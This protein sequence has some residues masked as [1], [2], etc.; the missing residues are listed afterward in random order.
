MS[1]TLAQENA[2]PRARLAKDAL[3]T[4]ASLAIL[5]IAGLSIFAPPRMSFA[6]D[7]TTQAISSD[8]AVVYG[9]VVDGSDRPVR[10]ATVVIV[11]EEN[12]DSVQVAA[13]ATA[14]DGTFRTELTGPFGQ[15]RVLVSAD[16]GGNVVRDS[17]C[18]DIDGG[19]AY[20][21]RVELVNRDYFVFL[22]VSSY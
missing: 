4:L 12:G 11:R 18:F 2:R 6:M 13:L 9:K 5:V 21:V 8:S 10:G 20:G 15:H 3:L 14:P 16:M 19:H 22:P 17:T 1:A 7:V